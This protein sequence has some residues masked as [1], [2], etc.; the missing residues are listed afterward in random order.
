MGSPTAPERTETMPTAEAR[1]LAD[2]INR[3]T[4][5]LDLAKAT[6]LAWR[7]AWSIRSRRGSLREFV[8]HLNSVLR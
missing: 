6:R 4:G 1:R 8:A 7:P 2:E 3:D 5:P